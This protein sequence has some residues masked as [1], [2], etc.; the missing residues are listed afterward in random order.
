MSYRLKIIWF[1]YRTFAYFVVADC[2]FRIKILQIDLFTIIEVDEIN[3][4]KLLGVS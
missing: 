4:N 2:I 3:I 1:V